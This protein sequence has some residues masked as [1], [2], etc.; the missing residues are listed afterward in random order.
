MSVDTSKLAAATDAHVKAADDLRS[1]ATH[2]SAQ[3]RELIARLEA[4]YAHDPAAADHVAHQSHLAEL[5]KQVDD[6]AAK[7][8]HGAKATGE[9]VAN[10]QPGEVPAAP[11]KAEEAKDAAA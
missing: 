1:L 2:L 9:T 7:L 8:D 5:Q 10:N 3:N 4:A 6:L 11:P